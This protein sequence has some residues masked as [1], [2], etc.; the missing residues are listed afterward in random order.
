[1]SG[2]PIACRQTKKTDRKQSVDHKHNNKTVCVM[3]KVAVNMPIYYIAHTHSY[4]MATHH[5]LPS[6][7]LARR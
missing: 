3:K 4:Q 6:L 1:M 2:K 7:S 5:L